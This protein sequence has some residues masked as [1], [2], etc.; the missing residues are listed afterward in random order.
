MVDQEARKRI[1]ALEAQGV[2]RDREIAD[3]SGRLSR[4]TATLEAVR[5]EAARRVDSPSVPSTLS[6]PEPAVPSV[7]T[8]ISPPAVPL[9]P[10]PA[11]FAS[12]IVADFLALF[13]EFGGKRFTLLWRGSRDCFRARDFH[14]RC[15]G[16]AN[17][18][19]LIE[20]TAGNIFGGFTPVEWESAANTIY[21]ADPS[22]KSFIGGE[23]SN[24]PPSDLENQ[25]NL[26]GASLIIHESILPSSR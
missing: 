13:A 14:K 16:Q 26:R 9:P 4:L 12:L 3:L 6:M 2:Q 1:E 10:P 24:D 11:G 22:L 15:D 7:P 5:A 20:D 19:T 25:K 8:S 23:K 18:L 17:T 21:T